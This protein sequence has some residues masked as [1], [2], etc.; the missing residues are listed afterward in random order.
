[1][2]EKISIVT[3]LHGE[4]EFIPLIQHNFNQFCNPDNHKS[5][6]QELELIIVDDGK[7]NLTE[8]FTGLENCIYLHLGEEEIYKFLDQ[9]EEGFKQPNKTSLKV[10]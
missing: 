4:K 3:I 8:F 5:Y 1:M 7:E 10:S 6:T 9:I 2:A